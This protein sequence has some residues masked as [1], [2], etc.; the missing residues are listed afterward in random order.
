MFIFPSRAT[1]YFNI[2]LFYPRF[3]SASEKRLP[4]CICQVG[5][6]I[7]IKIPWNKQHNTFLIR[8]RADFYFFTYDF[9]TYLSNNML[10]GLDWSGLK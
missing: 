10:I 7:I 6:V 3:V 2:I 9:N 8:I 1:Q 5:E 4:L